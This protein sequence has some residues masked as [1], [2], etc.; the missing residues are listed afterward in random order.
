MT[1]QRR[2]FLA[3]GTVVRRPLPPGLPRPAAAVEHGPV[4]RYR[5][6]NVEI[7]GGGFV[8]GIVHH[9]KKRGLVYVRT[10]IGGAAGLDPR[11]RRSVQLLEWVGWGEETASLTG[12]ESLA[13]NPRDPSRL[14]LAV[15]TYTNEWSPINGA[16]LR[17][18]DQ[19]RTFRRTDLPFKLGGNEPGRSMG[20]RLAV[21]PCDGTDPV[22]RYAQPGSVA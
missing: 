11:T 14:Y 3:L 7:V 2:H 5:W 6:R 9:P 18:T 8:T 20:E 16:I 10:D 21:D 19:G 17:S 1:L 22:L 12:V 13:L 4:P 15:G